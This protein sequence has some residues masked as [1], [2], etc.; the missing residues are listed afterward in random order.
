MKP[1]AYLTGL[2]PLEFVK[3]TARRSFRN[4]SL[5]PVRIKHKTTHFALI[6]HRTCHMTIA[7][8]CDLMLRLSRRCDWVVAE[9]ASDTDQECQLSA[10]QHQ[11]GEAKRRHAMMKKARQKYEFF[12]KQETYK[13]QIEVCGE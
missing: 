5:T 11:L 13:K 12:K 10:L 3:F 9:T 1:P 2:I 8:H 7:L 6:G 4:F